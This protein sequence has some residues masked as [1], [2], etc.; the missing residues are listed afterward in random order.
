MARLRQEFRNAGIMLNIV[1]FKFVDEEEKKA[2]EQ[3][4]VVEQLP[5]PGK[6]Y[7]VKDAANLAYEAHT[8]RIPAEGT[9]VLVILEPVAKK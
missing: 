1:G 2:L 8:Q 4:Q 3:F 9:K 7:H 6:L 5:L